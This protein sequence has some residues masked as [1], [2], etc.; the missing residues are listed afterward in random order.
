MWAVLRAKFGYWLARR[1]FGQRWAQQNPKV[2][3]WMQNQYVRMANTG[4][5]EAQ[6]FY[7]H[8]LYHKGQGKAAKYEGLRYLRLAAEQGDAKAAYQVGMH[9][10]KEADTTQAKRW[11][12]MAEQLE[13]PMAEVQ[14]DKLRQQDEA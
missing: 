14:L 11:F 9:F 5:S 13:H 3:E 7:G 12:E 4:H 6:A 1:L 8:L 10:L 2:W